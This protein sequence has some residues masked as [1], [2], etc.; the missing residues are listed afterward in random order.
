MNI[1]FEQAVN[2]RDLVVYRD[3][4]ITSRTLASEVNMDLLL[5]AMDSGESI[6][7][8]SSPNMKVIYV[9]EG[10]LNL[11]LQGQ[12][13]TVNAGEFFA[14]TRNTEHSIE[15]PG[16]CKFVQMNGLN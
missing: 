8:E 9:L 11:T 10:Q 4:Q 12:P 6:S 15:A 5:Y 16:R 14:I 13:V 1:P 2:L 7:N 3:R